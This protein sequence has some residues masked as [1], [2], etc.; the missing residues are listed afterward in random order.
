MSVIL[1][2]QAG[3]GRT[4]VL[5]AAYL[6]QHF[7]YTANEAV[8]WLRLC[9]PGSVIGVQHKFL[10]KCQPWLHYEGGIWR[11]S[12]REFGISAEK[13]QRFR[14]GIY[15]INA[16]LGCNQKET[17]FVR[18]NIQIINGIDPAFY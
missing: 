12:M 18:Q 15:S 14:Y 17:N 1:H 8:G 6:M 3:L 9:R 7:H 4:G 11:R 5:I 13:L 2:M 16:R 10:N